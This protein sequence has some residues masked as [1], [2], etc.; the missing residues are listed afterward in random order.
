[1]ERFADPTILETMSLGEKLLD[2][3]LVM[4]LGMGVTF[5]VLVFLMFSIGMLRLL[6]QDKKKVDKPAEKQPV[7]EPVKAV[8]VP[9]GDDELLAVITA[10]LAASQEDVVAVIAA[11]IAAMETPGRRLKIQSIRRVS[12]P[13]P[14]WAQDGLMKNMRRM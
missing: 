6:F 9:E 7:A 11:A 14:I 5:L 4:L 8:P 10:A 1:M 2:S 12:E 13:M 3:A